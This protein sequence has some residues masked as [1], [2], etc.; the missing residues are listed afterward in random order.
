[1]VDIQLKIRSASRVEFVRIQLSICT[2]SKLRES[3]L[4]FQ[5]SLREIHK[6]DKKQYSVDFVV[7][8]E[9]FIRDVLLLFCYFSCLFRCIFQFWF[10]PWH[11]QLCSW[12]S[13]SSS[14]HLFCSCFIRFYDVAPLLNCFLRAFASLLSFWHCGSADLDN[15]WL[16]ESPSVLWCRRQGSNN[17]ISCG[18][19]S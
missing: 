5:Y 1:M 12:W 18:S 10:S 16:L 6:H 3:N 14:F 11:F 7:C 19:G 4:E 9:V 17:I 2:W 15:R 8:W 13:S